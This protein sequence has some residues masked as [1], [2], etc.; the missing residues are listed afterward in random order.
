MWDEFKQAFSA[1]LGTLPEDTRRELEKLETKCGFGPLVMQALLS[2]LSS[3][4]SRREIQFLSTLPN[5][6]SL[7]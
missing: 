5:L 3:S 4:M 7:R 2:S 1:E 6:S